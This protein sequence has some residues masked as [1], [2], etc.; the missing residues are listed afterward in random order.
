MGF[1]HAYHRLH[2]GSFQKPIS[3]VLG[4]CWLAAGCFF[5]LAAMCWYDGWGTGGALL[6]SAATGSQL[7]II[8]N[9]IDARW[10]TLGNLVTLYAALYG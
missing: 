4:W 10:G 6:V 3:K 2:A 7:L 5:V 8:Q 1:A 9:W